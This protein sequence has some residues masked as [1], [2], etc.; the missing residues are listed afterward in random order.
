MVCTPHLLFLL[1]GRGVEPPTEFSKR[2]GLAMTLT[3]TGVAARGSELFRKGG[4]ATGGS[5]GCNF[6]IK[7]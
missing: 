5:R 6:Y 1:G 3:L 7:K 2:R 4:G